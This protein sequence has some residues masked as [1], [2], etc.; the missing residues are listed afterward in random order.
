MQINFILT[1][2]VFG[3][4]YSRHAR[5]SRPGLQRALVRSLRASAVDPSLQPYAT[6]CRQQMAC[7]IRRAAILIVPFRRFMSI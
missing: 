3:C 1:H 6:R 2:F 5:Q 4:C 7:H